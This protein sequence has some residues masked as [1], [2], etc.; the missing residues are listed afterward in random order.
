MLK[1]NQVK[2]KCFKSIMLMLRKNKKQGNRK[3]KRFF[4]E[5]RGIESFLFFNQK[6]LFCPYL[7]FVFFIIIH[8]THWICVPNKHFLRHQSY[9]DLVFFVRPTSEVIILCATLI[10]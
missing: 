3:L 1:R 6:Y 7:A 9:K 10:Q 2:Q 5:D 4:S 8:M